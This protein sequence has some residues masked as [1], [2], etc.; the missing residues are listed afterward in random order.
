MQTFP[1]KKHKT[2]GYMQRLEILCVCIKSVVEFAN[3]NDF[4]KQSYSGRLCKKIPRNPK[5]Q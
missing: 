4:S 3:D 5:G 1:K 2:K